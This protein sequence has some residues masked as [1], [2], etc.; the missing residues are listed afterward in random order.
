[1]SRTEASHRQL[2]TALLHRHGTTF[3]SEAGIRLGRGTPAPLWQL[4]VLSILVSARIQAPIAV[5]AAKALNRE[6]WTTA[7]KLS[8]ST[9]ARRAK[10]L[11]EAGYARY[12]ERTATML[13]DTAELALDGYGGDLRRL[14]EDA[15]RDVAE[16]HRLLKGFK[17][18]GD[19][20]ADAFL[21]EAQVVWDEARPFFDDRALDAADRLGLPKDPHRL[22]GTVDDGDVA[23]LAAAL[24]RIGLDGDV[25]E[26]R[27]AARS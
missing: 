22:A 8:G 27:E 15:G 20:G 7:K 17:G 14:R 10:V 12:D 6:G 5:A 2:S 1:M 25:D 9:W 4:L 21:R 26:V 11:N 3:A 18:I 19:V 23:R 16:E 24:V 13:G